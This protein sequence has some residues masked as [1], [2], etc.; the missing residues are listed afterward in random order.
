M[1]LLSTKECGESP[2]I[3]V[4]HMFAQ[5]VHSVYNGNCKRLKLAQ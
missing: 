1:G 3:L 5:L 2:E 4:C